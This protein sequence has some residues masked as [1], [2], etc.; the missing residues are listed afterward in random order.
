MPREDEVCDRGEDVF[1]VYQEPVHVEEEGADW[2]EPGGFSDEILDAWK[3]H[4]L[5]WG[6]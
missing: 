3:G 2:G 4:P 5:F 6:I 1:A